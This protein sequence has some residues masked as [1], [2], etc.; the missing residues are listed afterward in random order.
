[1]QNVIQET[2]DKLIEE[3]FCKCIESKPKSYNLELVARCDF[4]N[5][6]VCISWKIENFIAYMYIFHHQV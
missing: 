6:N 4:S 5:T 3:D 1:M 2:Y